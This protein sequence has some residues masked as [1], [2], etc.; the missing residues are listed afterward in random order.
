M[1]PLRDFDRA[2]GERLRR[3]KASFDAD[4]PGKAEL[5]V[6]IQ[7]YNQAKSRPGPI[8]SLRAAWVIAAAMMLTGGALAASS[9][10]KLRAL[11][12]SRLLSVP[13]HPGEQ[14]RAAR[15][16]GYVVERG[17]NRLEYS[18]PAKLTLLPGERA[19]LI[20]DNTR[21]EL[22]GPGIAQIRNAPQVAHWVARF[23]PQVWVPELETREASPST[24]NNLSAG[25]KQE[26]DPPDNSKTVRRTAAVH[27]RAGIL[28]V[29]HVDN[30]APT[31][32]NTLVQSQLDGAWSRA[33]S[34]LR[35]GDDVA[36]TAALGEISGSSDP[37]ARDA[38]KLAQAQL[39][40]AAGRHAKAMP[41]L[42]E[43]AQSGAT[44][45]VRR[46]AQEIFV[47]GN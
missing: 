1:K 5:L 9:V 43:L 34:A 7:R 38:A 16:S 10:L 39:D 27:P 4:R 8:F 15:S 20:I 46:R 11:T 26:T 17:G 19:A 2:E 21:T 13:A 25:T 30:T 41:V 14:P 42:N 24:S 45:F 22:I 36:A 44:P 18:A 33:A 40:L 23:E 35:R 29:R 47:N 12:P 3:M 6:A 32:A 28:S 31:L 37:A